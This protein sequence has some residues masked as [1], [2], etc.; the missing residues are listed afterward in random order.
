MRTN[1]NSTLNLAEI[2][3]EF[4]I[5]QRTFTRRFKDA[6]GLKASTYWQKI[7]IEAAQELLSSSNLSIQEIA[8]QVGYPDQGNLTRLFKQ[9]LNITPRGYRAMVRKKLFTQE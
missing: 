1:L 5:S 2:A 7:K 6:T 8:F 4:K 3:A 9:I